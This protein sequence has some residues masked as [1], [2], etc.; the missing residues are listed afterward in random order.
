MQ[1]LGVLAGPPQLHPALAGAEHQLDG[2]H[3]ALQRAASVPDAIG[4]AD[5]A[6]RLKAAFLAVTNTDASNDVN[7]ARNAGRALTARLR[8]ARWS[9]SA[10]GE[11]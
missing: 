3:R 11:G 1:Q 9:S 10:K 2:A 8:D 5:E 7:I 6:G 4:A